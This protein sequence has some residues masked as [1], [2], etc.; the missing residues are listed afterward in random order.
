YVPLNPELPEERLAQLLGIIQPVALIV[1]DAGRSALSARVRE[2]CS[3]PILNSLA[4]LPAFDPED[5]PREM[6]A[7]DVGY[8]IFTSGSTGVPKGVLV[9]NRAVHHLVNM[10]QE[11]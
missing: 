4:E 6:G 2:A 11:V 5:R 3:G 1:D 9:P 10:L 8:M 7:E